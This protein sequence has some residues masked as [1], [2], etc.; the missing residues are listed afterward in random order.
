MRQPSLD[1]R[2][3][4]ALAAGGLALGA[5][6]T[7][8]ARKTSAAD[9]FPEL[10]DQRAKHKAIQ[11][12]EKAA[13]ITR[14]A[15][16]LRAQGIDALLI[17]SG[18]TLKY[19]SDVR[20]GRSERLFALLVLANGEHF[21]I[22]PYFEAPRAIERIEEHGPVAPVVTWHED[23][24][25]WKP[26]ARALAARGAKNIAIEP[27]ARAFVAQSLAQQLGAQHVLL[28]SAVLDALRGIKDEHELAL[29]RAA[30]ELT[31][32]AISVAARGFEAGMTDHEIGA[33]IQSA[34]SA[35]GLTGIWVLPL[36]GA[37]AALPHGAPIGRR[38]QRG[39]TILVDTGGALHDYQSDISRSWCFGEAASGKMLHAWNTVREAQQVAFEQSRPGVACREVDAAARAII[40][41]EGFGAAYESF[42]HRLGHGIGMDGHEGPYFDGGSPIRL[43]SGMTFSDEPGIYVAGEIGIRLEDIVQVTKDAA[44]HFGGWQ[45]SPDHPD[46]APH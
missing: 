16:V 17:E 22:C 15:A 5:C 45:L 7:S 35:L 1:R 24:Y 27:S 18:S 3:A 12:A 39:D 34:Q 6:G 37:S 41:R 19:L 32:G 8:P 36:I 14:C 13:R 9:A 20:W 10:H 28:G 2:R 40:A 33:R 31:Q 11:P 44:D 43:Q 38:L 21:W 25:A 4:L 29:L 26:L 30:N 23:E 42:A 46:S